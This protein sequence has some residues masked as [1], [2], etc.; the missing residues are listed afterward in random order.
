MVRTA[1]MTTRSKILWGVS[2]SLWLL[3]GAIE[4]SAFTMN[5][6]AVMHDIYC[7]DH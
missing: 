4:I 3:V 1:M 7:Q 6:G 5:M 2:L